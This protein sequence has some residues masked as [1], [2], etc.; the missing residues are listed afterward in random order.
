MNKWRAAGLRWV[1]GAHIEAI[2]ATRL[3]RVAASNSSRTLDLAYVS[4][5]PYEM[6]FTAND[7]QHSAA[8]SHGDVS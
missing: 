8:F 1:A 6:Q 5:H 4:D 2:D 3:A 7:L